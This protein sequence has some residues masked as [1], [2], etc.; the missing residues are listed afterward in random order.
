MDKRISLQDCNQTLDKSP[1][2]RSTGCHNQKDRMLTGIR[3][4]PRLQEFDHDLLRNPK[5][6]AS[7][8]DSIWDCHLLGAGVNTHQKTHDGENPSP[9]VVV[10]VVA[11]NIVLGSRKESWTCPYWAQT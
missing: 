5:G 2:T 10:V 4:M 9:N 3:D 11:D 1:S 8:L 7:I 6:S